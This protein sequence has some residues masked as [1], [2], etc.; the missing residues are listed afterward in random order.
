MMKVFFA[1]IAMVAALALAAGGAQA[2]S[3]ISGKKIE[4]NV[5]PNK[6]ADERKALW[7]KYGGWCAIAEW[8]PTVAKCVESKEGD[9]TF[10]TLTLQDGAK[11]KE[12]LLERSD[13]SYKY[14]IVESPLPVKNYQ[15]QFA[16]VP[17]DDD[18]DEVNIS[19]AATYDADGKSDKEARG[20]IDGIFKDGLK[21]IEAK[22]PKK[23]DDDD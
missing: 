17:D 3:L 16:I 4:V 22:L 11:I 5:D 20:V 21:A 9:V 8:H 7:A 14:A 19:W 10:R 2:A 18:L 12:K 13:V 6:I 23:S 1:S 15:A